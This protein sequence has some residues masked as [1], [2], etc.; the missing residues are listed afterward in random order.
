LKLFH[1]ALPSFSRV[2]KQQF[3]QKMIC[4]VVGKLTVVTLGFDKII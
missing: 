4:M 1:M 3:T 2:I